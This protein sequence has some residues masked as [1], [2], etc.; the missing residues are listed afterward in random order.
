MRHQRWLR[1]RSAAPATS[2]R[3]GMHEDTESS[4]TSRQGVGPGGELRAEIDDA[5]WRYDKVMEAVTGADLKASI[6]ATVQAAALGALLTTATPST[7]AATSRVLFV[8]GIGALLA[9]VATAGAAIFPR[10]GL[11]RPPPQHDALHFSDLQQLQP[12]QLIEHLASQPERQRLE[13]L[14]YR[15]IWAS[16]IVWRKYVCL[17][18]SLLAA[19]VAAAMVTA[20]YLL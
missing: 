15:L 17:Q 2:T 11:R 9:G 13:A 4:P 8:A 5:R 14:A 16:K 18:W 19:G 12:E 7:L 6:I 3:V 10:H 20:A 1:G